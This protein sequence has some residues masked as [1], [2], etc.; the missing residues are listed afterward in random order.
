MI[1]PRNTDRV[2]KQLRSDLPQSSLA[3]SCFA[4]EMLEFN[5][6]VC[7]GL[8]LHVCLCV[9]QQIIDV[10]LQ[11]LQKKVSPDLKTQVNH[12]EASPTTNSLGTACEKTSYCNCPLDRFNKGISL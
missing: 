5:V 11:K 2:D 12:K 4:A 1:L 7:V 9:K 6:H 3:A 8:W 10:S